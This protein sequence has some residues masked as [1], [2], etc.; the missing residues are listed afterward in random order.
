MINLQNIPGHGS[1]GKLRSPR[2]SFPDQSAFKKRVAGEFHHGIC[3]RGWFE[4]IDDECG[5]DD[6][7]GHDG[8]DDDRG[9]HGPGETGEDA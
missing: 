4:G 1:P 9:W 3:N 5:I 6:E 7:S 8:P 2:Q